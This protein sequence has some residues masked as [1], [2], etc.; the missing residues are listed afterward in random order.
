[1]KIPP[2]V[3]CII[4]DATIGTAEARDWDEYQFSDVLTVHLAVYRQY[5]KGT[6]RALRQPVHIKKE[7]HTPAWYYVKGRTI[8]VF[9]QKDR[10]IIPWKYRD[11]DEDQ[12][13]YLATKRLASF[14]LGLIDYRTGSILQ[15]QPGM[16]FTAFYLSQQGKLPGIQRFFWPGNGPG[17]ELFPEPFAVTLP[18]SQT[19]HFALQ[20]YQ[21][22]Q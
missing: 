20:L 4:L 17:G 2:L 8:Q 9:A 1:M 6:F 14:M 16:T 11:G 3:R 10:R 15:I 19:S 12:N 18:N 13:S 21:E 7:I 5:Y 22:L